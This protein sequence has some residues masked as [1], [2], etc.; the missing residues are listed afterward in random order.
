[1]RYKTGGSGMANMLDRFRLKKR[2]FNPD[3]LDIEDLHLPIEIKEMDHERILRDLKSNL[4][5][6]K[7]LGYRFKHESELNSLQEY[8][9][10]EIG[11]LLRSVK[12]KIDLKVEKPKEYFGDV[13]LNHHYGTIQSLVQDIIKKYERNVT[14]TLSEIQLKNEMLWTPIE[15]GQLLY[16]LSF[17]WKKDLED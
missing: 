1:M 8:N 7:L 9:S 4:K 2:K 14:K 15:A 10:L 6:Y 11:I 16:Y 5:N 13:I 17:Y 12:D 3:L